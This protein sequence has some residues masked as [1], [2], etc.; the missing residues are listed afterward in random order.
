MQVQERLAMITRRSRITCNQLSYR[1]PKQ[2]FGGLFYSFTVFWGRQSDAGRGR[3]VDL[4]DP[5]TQLIRIG[6]LE[7]VLSTI[8]QTRKISFT[9]ESSSN[10]MKIILAEL[11]LKR[12]IEHKPQPED[13]LPLGVVH[14]YFSFAAIEVK[15]RLTVD[16]AIVK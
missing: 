9:I 6:S 13:I 3:P 11:F 15:R 1:P 2:L 12:S 7:Q 16:E 14:C 8:R 5:Q 10:L 4:F